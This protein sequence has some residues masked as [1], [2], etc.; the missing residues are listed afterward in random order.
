MTLWFEV[1]DNFHEIFRFDLDFVFE[2]KG[3]R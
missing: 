3:T 2:A 1:S